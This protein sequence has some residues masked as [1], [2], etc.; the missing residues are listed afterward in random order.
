MKRKN[1]A[2]IFLFFLTFGLAQAKTVYAKKDG[3]TLY[4]SDIIKVI[5]LASML[6][7]QKISSSDK[8]AIHNFWVAFFK[9]NPAKALNTSKYLNKLVKR[10]DSSKSDFEYQLAVQ[11]AYRILHYEWTYRKIG[12]Y[13]PINT[14]VKKYNP[15]FEMDKNKKF[16]VQSKD[17]YKVKRK[18]KYLTGFMLNSMVKVVEFVA[19]SKLSNSDK[20]KVKKL[21]IK[22]FKANPA[23][24]TN[25]YAYMINKLLPQIYRT[26]L[27]KGIYSQSPSD[28]VKIRED[29][30]Q[31][32]YFDVAKRNSLNLGY[33]IM[34]II[35]KYNPILVMDKKHKVL[36]PESSL[37]TALSQYNFLEKIIGTPVKITKEI[38][39]KEKNRMIK[40]FVDREDKK[41][42]R[43]SSYVSIQLQEV[44]ANY[45]AQKKANLARRMKK[46]YLASASM[47]TIY[48]PLYIQIYQNMYNNYLYS[49]SLLNLTYQ[50]QLQTIRIV[51]NII[52][53]MTKF[54]NRQSLQISGATILGEQNNYYIVEYP[55]R[56]GERYYVHI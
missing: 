15:V 17:G 22:D 8:W 1:L 37:N 39:L 53:D 41:S 20:A 43:S 25:D 16:F 40:Y 18:G 48:N 52:D 27:P 4:R 54:T 34:D 29:L 45:S 7:R 3:H 56:P 35:A 23:E 2:I 30:Y 33:N 12:G 51:D 46:S 36:V 13:K 31:E 38:Y 44:W 49:V 28:L 14:I 19:Q 47:D 24:S 9:E 55:E 10:V 50:V 11:A 26:A 32:F 42:Y 6:S 5:D 21:A